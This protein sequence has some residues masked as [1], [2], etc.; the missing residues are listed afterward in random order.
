MRKL[1]FLY[2]MLLS[3][4]MINSCK[5]TDPQPE[6]KIRLKSFELRFDDDRETNVFWTTYTYNEKDLIG[7]VV[8]NDTTYN[9][10]RNQF[11]STESIYTYFYNEEDFLIRRTGT[12]ISIFQNRSSEIIYQYT[13]GRLDLE[14]FG[15]RVTEYR[16]DAVGNVVETIS[17][18]LTNGN[19]SFLKYN[20]NIPAGV[21]PNGTGYLQ[22]DDDEKI[23]YNSEVL[24]EKYER[25]VDGKLFFERNKTYAPPKLHLGAL[26]DFK[27]WPLIKSQSFRNGIEKSIRSFIYENGEKI[28]VTT[29]ELTQTY[30]AEGFL[31]SNRGQE[32]LNQNTTEP[33][34]RKLDFFYNYEYY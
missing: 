8:F 34:T 16:Y 23:F 13:D 15:D 18:S 27:G 22:E 6:Q 2:L 7:Q 32:L 30:N 28:P 33:I 17:T 4:C 20:N 10:T 26:P 19:K 11:E 14:N 9:K 3:V 31:S 12:V 21:D 29:R 24:E 1:G 25:Y 5:T